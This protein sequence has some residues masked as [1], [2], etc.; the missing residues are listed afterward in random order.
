MSVLTLRSR[1]LFP[2]DDTEEKVRLTFYEVAHAHPEVLPHIVIGKLALMSIPSFLHDSFGQ[3]DSSA[4]LLPLPQVH[5]S[6]IQALPFVQLLTG[7]GYV[8]E[9]QK[10]LNDL[11]GVLQEA[12]V[13]EQ[14]VAITPA[15]AAETIGISTDRVAEALY[16]QSEFVV[17]Q[18]GLTSFAFTRQ[19]DPQA[20]F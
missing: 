16:E 19:Y 14:Y 18:Q 7:R 20:D 6:K 8:Q 3:V 10:S 17:D 12:P 11:S 9:R 5:P 4:I 15:L 13:F 1:N 2:S